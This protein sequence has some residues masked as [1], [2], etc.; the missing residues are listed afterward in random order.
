MIPVI[1]IEGA[2]ASGKSAL[3]IV[4]AEA[5][6]TEIISADSRQVYRYLDIGTAKLTKEE[7]KEL[8][9]IN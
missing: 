7:Q 1:T 6:N 5:L 2:T 8:N 9:I 4:L 3:A